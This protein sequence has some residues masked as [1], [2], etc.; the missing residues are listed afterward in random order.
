[1]PN[2]VYNTVTVSGGANA[3]AELK[4]QMSKPYTTYYGDSEWDTE[5]KCWTTVPAEQF[6]ES[7]FSFWNIKHPDERVWGEY[8][9]V[10]A[11]VKSD[12]SIKDPDWFTK[13]KAV[14]EYSNHWYDWN[15]R[16]WDTKW[17]ARNPSLKDSG[18]SLEYCFDTAWSPIISL[19]ILLSKSYPTLLFHYRYEEEQGWGGRLDIKNGNILSQ[20]EWDIPASHSE[21]IA[22]RGVCYSCER[23][24]LDN[25]LDLDTITESD[26]E[27][28]EEAVCSW[29][30][31][32]DCPNHD[33]Y[34]RTLTEYVKNRDGESVG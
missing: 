22:I 20:Q 29:G 6:Q 23:F 8:F 31:Y 9:A 13:H 3:L 16:E 25:D 14:A 28:L 19:I 26:I 5:N 12:V 15:C 27:T 24:D 30:L 32:S 10:H 7:V 21:E 4:A 33:L 17:D 2:W 1:M 34:V 11:T 18:T